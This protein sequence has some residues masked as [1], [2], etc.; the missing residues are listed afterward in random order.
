MA[1]PDHCRCALTEPIVEMGLRHV[2]DHIAGCLPS[3]CAVASSQSAQ[4]PQIEFDQD[5]ENEAAEDQSRQH[6][7]TNMVR[8]GCGWTDTAVR[9]CDLDL[10]AV[11]SGS[12]CAPWVEKCKHHRHDSDWCCLLPHLAI[13]RIF[14][15]AST[16][17]FAFSASAQAADC[18][19]RLCVGI[20]VLQYVPPMDRP[21]IKANRI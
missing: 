3:T 8:F 2:G 12:Q 18:S 5:S 13:L 6:P 20:L 15:E 16:Q 14:Q 1:R 19:C 17:A 11:D 21:P 7:S 9:R 4:S 10:G